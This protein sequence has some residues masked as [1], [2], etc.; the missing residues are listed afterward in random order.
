MDDDALTQGLPEHTPGNVAPPR[1]LV[2]CSDG[3]VLERRQ[4]EDTQGVPMTAYVRSKSSR[5]AASLG[6]E[7]G[8]G[9]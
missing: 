4:V 9:D 2:G 3:N 6:S 7:T 5:G 8:S 1:N